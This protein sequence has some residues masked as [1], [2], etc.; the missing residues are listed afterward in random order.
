MTVQC[1]WAQQSI[2]QNPCCGAKDE[3]VAHIILE[4]PHW[5]RER[6]RLV[7]RMRDI[8]VEEPLKR[9]GGRSGGRG[10]VWVVALPKAAGVE[11]LSYEQIV[12]RGGPLW[13]ACVGV[14]QRD[15]EDGCMTDAVH[16]RVM[17]VTECFLRKVLGTRGT[18]WLDN[19]LQQRR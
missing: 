1:G 7:R 14:G 5:D 10:A 17:R 16:P 3:D 18:K 19:L 6:R 2:T 15:G 8:D 12:A 4:C 13:R 9:K 11:E